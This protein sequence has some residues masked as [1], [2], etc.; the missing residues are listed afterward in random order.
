M[1]LALHL[2]SEAVQHTHM[3]VYGLYRE[4]FWWGWRQNYVPVESFLYVKSIGAI[5]LTQPK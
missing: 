5:N 1:E 2:L 4:G 3:S